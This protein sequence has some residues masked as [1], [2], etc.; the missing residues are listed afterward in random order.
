V[1]GIRPIIVKY[2]SHKIKTEIYVV[3]RKL[4]GFASF[5]EPSSGVKA[6]YKNENFNMSKRRMYAEI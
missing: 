4:Q 2:K 3:R 1:K 6:I 5:E